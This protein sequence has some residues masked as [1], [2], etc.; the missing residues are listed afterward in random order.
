MLVSHSVGLA[1]G[2]VELAAQ[3]AGP[4]VTLE[5]A[6]GDPDGGLGTSAELI[7]QAI[8]RADAG[9]GVVVLGDLGSAI[10]TAREL[11]EGDDADGASALAGRRV[12]LADAPFVEGALAAAVTAAAGCSLDEVVRAAEA[13]RGASKF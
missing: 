4:E 13:T 10:L 2:L 8:V 11:L 12:V 6:G 1:R 9:H 3:V 7:V 5:A